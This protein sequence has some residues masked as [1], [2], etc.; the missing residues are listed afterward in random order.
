MI[1]M[2]SSGQSTVSLYDTS[3]GLFPTSALVYEEHS[4]TSHVITITAEG[5]RDII[6][7]I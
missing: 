5:G 7:C 3:S 4:G 2:Q 1:T 6:E